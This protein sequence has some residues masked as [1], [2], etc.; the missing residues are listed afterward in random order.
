MSSY[1]VDS[2]GRK[3]LRRLRKAPKEHH[4]E[5]L[6]Y[7][8]PKLL[9]HERQ[10]VW[11]WKRSNG[12]GDLFGFDTKGR[13]IV[14]EFKKKMGV[15]EIKKA[16]T[17]LSKA[18]KTFK[19]LPE[20]KIQKYYELF[21]KKYLSNQNCEQTF[22]EQFNKIAGHKFYRKEKL[23]YSYAVANYFTYKG[24]RYAKKNLKRRKRPPR[25]VTTQI[26]E[27]RGNSSLVAAEKLTL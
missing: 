11:V 13:P 9:N 25:L 26:L 23:L 3:K 22:N 7:M 19:N 21:R 20:K 15:P 10:I 27:S 18:K 16:M 1:W 24:L 12:P 17:Q 2:T 5:R 6:V 14:V 4:I 8:Y